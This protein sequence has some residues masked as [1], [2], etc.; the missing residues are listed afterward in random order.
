MRTLKIFF[1]ILLIGLGQRTLAQNSAVVLSD[2][3]V[4]KIMSPSDNALNAMIID[5]HVSDP[6][7]LRTLTFVFEDPRSN[8][9]DA[10]QNFSIVL[11]DGKAMIQV[12]DYSIPIENNSIQLSLKVRDQITMPY[13]SVVV[14]GLDANGLMTS[15]LKFDLRY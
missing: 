6:L 8:E 13:R 9:E 10:A 3:R 5:L 7:S 4:T 2:L 14:S 11:E 15:E 12:D 1:L